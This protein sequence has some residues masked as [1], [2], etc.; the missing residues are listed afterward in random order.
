LGQIPS[1][2]TRPRAR[3]GASPTA[4]TGRKGYT[5]ASRRCSLSRRTVGAVACLGK[6]VSDDDV[7]VRARRRGSRALWAREAS[8]TARSDET[9]REARVG[10]S[11]EK[12]GRERACQI[13]AETISPEN[14]SRD[15]N[16][17]SRRRRREFLRL[18][19]RTPS[20]RETIGKR[21]TE[22]YTKKTSRARAHHEK[23]PPP[24]ASRRR[25]YARAYTL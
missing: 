21:W 16:P 20:S 10:G 5:M 3:L 8:G 1:R 12:T 11:C 6:S 13:P 14:A 25:R 23:I 19:T 18:R 2:V 17:R 4:S 9:I 15:S 24:V 7:R 22:R